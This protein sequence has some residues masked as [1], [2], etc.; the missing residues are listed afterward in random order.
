MKIRISI[1]LAI[2]LLACESNIYNDGFIQYHPVKLTDEQKLTLSQEL[3]EK[4]S[5]YDEDEKMLATTINS[6]QYHIDS[7]IDTKVHDVRS[8]FRYAVQLL[9]M[10]GNKN[11]QRAFDILTKAISLQDQDTTSESCGVWPYFLEEPLAT[12]KSPVDY[13]WA[14]F[15]A[16]KL[17]DIWMGHNEKLVEPLRSKVKYALVLAAKAIQKRDVGPGYTNIAIMGTYVTYLVSHLFD[18]PEMQKYAEKRG[19]NFYEYTLDLGGFSEYNSPTYTVVALDEIAR[20]QNH[21]VEPVAKH[22]IDSLYTI[23]WDVIARHYHKPT[24]QWAGPHSRAYGSLLRQ[25]AQ[26]MINEASNGQIALD[27]QKA[28]IDVRIRHQIPAHLLWYFTDPKYPRLEVDIFDKNEPQ[29]VGMAYLTDAYA[30]SSCNMSSLWNQ[31]RPLLA[32]WGTHDFPKY[33]QLRFLHDDYDF[34]SALLYTQQN[35]NKVL[36]TISF[37]TNSGD[38][39]PFIGKI[40]DGRFL[41]RDMRL[42]F[43]F[44][45]VADSA[46]LMPVEDFEPTTFETEGMNFKLH[47]MAAAFDNLDGHWEKGGEETVSWM[48]YVIYHGDEKEFDLL[49]IEKAYLAFTYCM[50]PDQKDFNNSPGNTEI[51]NGKILA[52]WDDMQVAAEV[53]PSILIKPFL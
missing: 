45:N 25:N 35:E 47:L 26:S 33:M 41:A 6:W 32:Y 17:L 20:M 31:R 11:D 52:T 23:G 29:V 16:V 40:E 13:N 48:D 15:N 28:G 21:I 24:M 19:T 12:K 50:A 36:A 14:D 43:E 2:S 1:V 18:I 38:K 49:A 51:E 27:E 44:G 37:A 22:M 30:L 34:T 3:S 10:E 4:G 8:T 39:H 42:R 53:K 7:P 5:N 46:L 9:D